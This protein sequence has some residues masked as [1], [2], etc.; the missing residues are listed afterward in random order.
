[1]TIDAT[2]AV[3]ALGIKHPVRFVHEEMGTA[4]AAV[5]PT[6]PS[7]IKVNA[8]TLYQD[9]AEAGW[10]PEQ[11]IAHELVHVRQMQDIG[12]TDKAHQLYAYENRIRGY[13]KNRF[14]V[15][16]DRLAR[17]VAPLV[18]VRA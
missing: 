8:R 4:T 18:E 11:I 2:R 17:V 10:T 1:M 3:K 15:E 7:L 6:D 14:E 13:S 5:N 16:A 12:D 9:A